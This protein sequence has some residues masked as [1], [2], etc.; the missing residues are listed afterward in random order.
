MGD[1]SK[2]T[3][4]AK[5]SLAR[6]VLFQ[7]G[8]SGNAQAALDDFD[9]VR[10]A[11]VRSAHKRDLLEI[12]CRDQ[13]RIGIVKVADHLDKVRF[14]PIWSAALTSRCPRGFLE[15]WRRMENFSHA[16]NRVRFSGR[17]LQDVSCRRYRQGG[18]VPAL[19]ENLLICGLM[20]KLLKEIGCRNLACH[21]NEK[22]REIPVLEE[23]TWIKSNLDLLD[24]A[25]EWRFAWAEYIQPKA[26]LSDAAGYPSPD[27]PSCCGFE[28]WATVKGVV[29]IL[30]QAPAHPWRLSE[31]AEETQLSTR[32][33]QRRL[34]AGGQSFSRLVRSVRV[35]HA[36]R[37]LQNT[38]MSI[39]EAG[40]VSGFSD[41]AQFSRDFRASM[42]LSPTA[43][44]EA[45]QGLS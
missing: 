20:A 13:G 25:S 22:G 3:D 42:G 24:Q 38:D 4:F 27:M 32:T 45:A 44:R 29:K 39:T 6:M 21:I 37:Q 17:M 8:E 5:A 2:Q 10:D 30:G 16:T 12:L 7:L 9:A 41:S 23:G 31:I 35:Q 26:V 28:S 34:E 36:C 14:D 19:L 1:H 15:G 18:G 40:F 43:Y 11:H 33:L